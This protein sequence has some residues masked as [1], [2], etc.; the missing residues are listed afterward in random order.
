MDLHFSRERRRTDV[1]SHKSPLR[2]PLELVP[3]PLWAHA[4]VVSSIAPKA[5]VKKV[6]WT[7][8]SEAENKRDLMMWGFI[9]DVFFIDA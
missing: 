6:R 1:A 8:D 3:S 5:S 2:A 7:F 9:V 4:V